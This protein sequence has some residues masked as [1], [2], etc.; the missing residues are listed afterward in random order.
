MASGVS[1]ISPQIR[2]N[3]LVSLSSPRLAIC[4]AWEGEIA[5]ARRI[6]D[7]LRRRA[8]AQL[9]VQ[10]QRKRHDQLAA[11]YQQVQERLDGEPSAEDVGENAD[12]RRNDAAR[13][14][15]AVETASLSLALAEA[16]SRRIAEEIRKARRRD[17][18]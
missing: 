14:R 17:G 6:E 13:R 4:R 16:E 5:F 3:C 2:V 18:S 7:L 1:R 15:E 8:A 12:A 9:E 11:Q 10:R